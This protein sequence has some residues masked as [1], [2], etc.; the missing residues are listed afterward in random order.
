MMDRQDPS[1]PPSPLFP[2]SPFPPTVLQWLPSGNFGK[3]SYLAQPDSSLIQTPEVLFVSN[4][5]QVARTPLFLLC[6]LPHPKRR[7]LPFLS[8]I[9]SS[10][11]SSMMGQKST[12]THIRWTMT[13]SLRR[14]HQVL[15]RYVHVPF[16]LVNTKVNDYTESSK[17]VD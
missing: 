8:L 15:Y 5:A 16:Y 2:L 9:D 13:I 12:T 6:L 10:M 3:V 17:E 11:I 14:R 7:L 4:L 1:F